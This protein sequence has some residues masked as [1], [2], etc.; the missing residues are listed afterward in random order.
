MFV[1]SLRIN[2]RL[3]ISI[4]ILSES[5]LDEEEQTSYAGNSLSSRFK[6][7]WLKFRFIWL[8][9]PL[10]SREESEFQLKTCNSLVFLFF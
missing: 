7:I 10:A 1:Y 4:Q 5:P 6:L 2:D 9:V 3:M 8:F